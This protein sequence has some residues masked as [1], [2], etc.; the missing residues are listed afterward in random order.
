MNLRTK[1]KEQLIQA[2]RRPLSNDPEI[3]NDS[4]VSKLSDAEFN[5]LLFKLV[6]QL[7]Q[8]SLSIVILQAKFYKID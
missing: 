5:S 6:P 3:Q 7:Q 4:E 8:D 1:K 2:K